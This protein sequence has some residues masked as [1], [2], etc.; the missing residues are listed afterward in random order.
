MG[1]A[2][3]HDVGLDSLSPMSWPCYGL[4]ELIHILLTGYLLYCDFFIA[5]TLKFLFEGRP[6]WTRGLSLRYRVPLPSAVR[7]AWLPRGS[8]TGARRPALTALRG[9]FSERP[10]AASHSRTQCRD[11]SHCLL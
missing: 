9:L 4:G 1:C 7:S 2:R 5:L 11:C 3:R 10:G 8:L 6:S